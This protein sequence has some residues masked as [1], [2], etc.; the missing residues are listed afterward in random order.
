MEDLL[1]SQIYLDLWV[2]VRKDWREKED[3]LKM[4]GYRG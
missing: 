3:A 4:L 2:K 1:G